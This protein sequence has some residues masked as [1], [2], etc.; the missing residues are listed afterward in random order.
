MISLCALI[1]AQS[2]FQNIVKIESV[3]DRCSE[4]PVHCLSVLGTQQK[5]VLESVPTLPGL[6][7]YR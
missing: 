7:K 6:V 1:K 5:V 2:N 4:K 3:H